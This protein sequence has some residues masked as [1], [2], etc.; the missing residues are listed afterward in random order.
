MIINLLSTNISYNSCFSKLNLECWII[1]M[2]GMCMCYRSRLTGRNDIHKS[3]I[4][5]KK[6][7]NEEKK[8]WII[9]VYL[10]EPNV[11]EKSRNAQNSYSDPYISFF[12]SGQK[13]MILSIQ[14]PV[15]FGYHNTVFVAYPIDS[16][17]IASKREDLEIKI[18]HISLN[19]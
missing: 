10:L 9:S 5:L 13:K 1:L 19:C 7:F 3:D 15:S 11:S 14:W 18:L 6:T 17:F 16:V 12:L 2:S 8:Y 4:C